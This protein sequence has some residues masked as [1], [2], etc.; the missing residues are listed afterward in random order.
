MKKTLLVVALCLA[1]PS[2]HAGVFVVKELR[3]RVVS[4][5]PAKVEES[6]SRITTWRE[7]PRERSTQ[8]GDAL[9][10]GATLYD[11]RTGQVWLLDEAQKKAA[12]LKVEPQAGLAMLAADYGLEVDGS[13]AITTSYSFRAVGDSETIAGVQ[14]AHYVLDTGSQMIRVEVW[15]AGNTALS[16]ADWVAGL[17]RR[18]G[19]KP[20]PSVE[21]FLA[22]WAGLPGY[23][24]RVRTTASSKHGTVTV[25][26]VLVEA[27][28]TKVAP[29][30]LAIPADY[31]READAAS[32]F[33]SQY[34]ARER[35]KDQAFLREHKL[36]TRFVPSAAQP[37][38]PPLPGGSCVQKNYCME[39][40]GRDRTPLKEVCA[41]RYSDRPCD[42]KALLGIC[43][44]D[45][46]QQLFYR[47]ESVDTHPGRE[48]GLL[49][50]DLCPDKF[51][52]NPAGMLEAKARARA[53]VASG[54]H[55]HCIQPYH[56]VDLFATTADDAKATCFG[57]PV[58]QGPCP[59]EA[60]VGACWE[61][62]GLRRLT[63][64]GYCT[65]ASFE[66][67]NPGSTHSGT[68][69]KPAN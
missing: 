57:G 9:M 64:E 19:G 16:N 12:P 54:G 5:T 27:R 2:A 14:A 17:R 6:K 26:N 52:E 31:A 1:T 44:D 55:W 67:A 41:A 13:G 65:G 51:I 61:S 29:T 60:W 58:G 62:N 32:L 22:A 18:L 20:G 25:D 56:C 30:L 50:K 28:T 24:V 21:R 8:E 35:A 4:G 66:P 3:T 10:L 23:P 33:V 53:F 49:I 43:V 42:R 68:G 38:P 48:P 47:Y 63:S 36:D 39:S 34:L 7:G 40:F 46:N 45:S 11:A 59:T 69:D 37:L 15:V